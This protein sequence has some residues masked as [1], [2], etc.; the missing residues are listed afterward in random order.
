MIKLLGAL[1]ILTGIFLVLLNFGLSNWVV[2]ALL[3]YLLIKSIAFFG[4]IL[5]VVDLAVLVIAGIFIFFGNLSFLLVPGG[6]YLIA[7]G[8]YSCL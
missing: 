2:I 4:D 3:I 8:F 7:K 6:V 1:D 5:S